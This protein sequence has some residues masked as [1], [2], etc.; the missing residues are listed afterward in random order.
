MPLHGS[1]L[2]TVT[3]L[4][5][6]LPLAEAAA[7]PKLTLT[8]WRIEPSTVKENQPWTVKLWVGNLGN[9]AP[10]KPFT[11]QV[12]GC[13]KEYAKCEKVYATQEIKTGTPDLAPGKL[14]GREIV[15]EIKQGLAKG[16]H[17]ILVVVDAKKDNGDSIRKQVRVP[18]GFQKF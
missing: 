2:L 4:L 10:K 3:A 5:L 11:V 14:P 17:F 1:R 16:E 12:L 18:V 8:T 7:D 13:D 9:E 15:M 6:A